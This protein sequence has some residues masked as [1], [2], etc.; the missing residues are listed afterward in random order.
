MSTY[1]KAMNGMAGVAL[2]GALLLVGFVPRSAAAQDAHPG[3]LPWIGCWEAMG[4][5]EDESLLCIRPTADHGVEMLTVTETKVLSQAT[6]LADGIDHPVSREGCEGSERAQ[7]SDDGRRIYL[8]A[9][10]LCEG[11]VQRTT[12]GLM[13]MNTPYEWMDVK[14]AAVSG[15]D[16]AWAQRYRLASRKRTEAAGFEDLLMADRAMS[17]SA[18][19]ASASA[20]IEIEDVMDATAHVSPKAVE[21]WVA[22]RGEGFDLN[23]DQLVRMADAGVPGNVVD[24]MV[25]V[26]FPR[27]FTVG[28]AGEADAMLP[29]EE[30]VDE[31]DRYAPRQ[32]YDPF[33]FNPLYPGYYSPYGRYGFGYG[34]GSGYFGYGGY[35]YGYGGYYGG[36]RPVYV[37]VTPRETGGHGRIVKG[38]GYIPGSGSS[39]TTGRTATRRGSTGGS[40][41]A[42]ASGSGGRSSGSA[43]AGRSSSG[44]TA[45]RRGGG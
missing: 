29:D 6:V 26:S 12:S 22:E 30:F 4:E 20:E 32:Y 3:W 24:V 45:K 39:G 15:Q 11:G 37:E 36:Y 25:A 44:R 14:A 43:S 10:Y 21:A 35:G 40:S 28:R 9:E 2:A 7:F 1:R 31:Y 5:L 18:A 8:H 38:R 42:A 41:G 34:Y 19:R 16:V 13:S 27:R 33:Y 17:V 23:G